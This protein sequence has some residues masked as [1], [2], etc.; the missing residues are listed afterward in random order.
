M[1]N[2]NGNLLGPSRA[3]LMESACT[4]KG[5][6]VQGTKKEGRN[7]AYKANSIARASQTPTALTTNRQT[8]EFIIGLRL[9]ARS[10]H[11]FCP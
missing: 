10:Y 1:H 5:G 7:N 4:I 9:D 11:L 2:Y 3:V 8:A 6:F